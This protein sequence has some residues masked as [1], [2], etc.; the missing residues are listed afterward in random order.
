VVPILPELYAAD[1]NYRRGMAQALGIDP[2]TPVVGM[3]TEV[4]RR[5]PL[6]LTPAADSSVAM[7]VP[8]RAIRLVRVAGPVGELTPDGLAVTELLIAGRG[9]A[10]SWAQE[11]RAVYEAAGLRN[12]LLCSSIL[13]QLGDRPRDACGR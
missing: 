3:L 9:N 12:A 8:W 2:E 4:A 13:T 6:C 10:D 1:A 5:R 7:G 11:T